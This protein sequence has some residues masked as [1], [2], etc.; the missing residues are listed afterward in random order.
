MS[1]C[2]DI[3]RAETSLVLPRL[4]KTRYLT[5]PSNRA[6]LSSLEAHVSATTL[7]TLSRPIN[8]SIS[9]PV[10]GES[11][12]AS[13]VNLVPVG[14]SEAGLYRNEDIDTLHDK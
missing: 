5:K 4:L 7:T 3:V 10:T 1:K 11:I 12:K 13:P 8:Q 14:I 9:L 6:E 2:S